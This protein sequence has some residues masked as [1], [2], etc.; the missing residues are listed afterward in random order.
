[1]LQQD[2]ACTAGSWQWW[3][4]CSDGSGQLTGQWRQAGRAAAQQTAGSE[5]G[6]GSTQT[7]AVRGNRMETQSLRMTHSTERRHGAPGERGLVTA[8]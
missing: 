8:T 7:V 6:E 2:R 1:M 3:R 4:P 5:R